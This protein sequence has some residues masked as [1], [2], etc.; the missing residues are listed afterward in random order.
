MINIEFKCLKIDESF[1]WKARNQNSS[2]SKKYKRRDCLAQNLVTSSN[3]SC[4]I[5]V[6]SP[7]QYS[8]TKIIYNLQKTIDYAV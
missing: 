6:K 3:F 5:I 2:K 4:K 7:I 1:N 8:K